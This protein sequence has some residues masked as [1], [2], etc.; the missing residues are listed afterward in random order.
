MNNTE[1]ELTEIYFTQ[2]TAELF[3]EVNTSIINTAFK[4]IQESRAALTTLGA[5]QNIPISLFIESYFGQV[6]TIEEVK[7]KYIIYIHPKGQIC[8]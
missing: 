8:N 5:F 7:K 4:L 3:R 1:L 2:Q 6:P